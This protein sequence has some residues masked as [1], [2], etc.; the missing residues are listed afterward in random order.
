MRECKRSYFPSERMSISS[1]CHISIIEAIFFS[2]LFTFDTI[3]S[4]NVSLSLVSDLITRKERE[5]ERERFEQ[6]LSAFGD[7]SILFE[8]S[9]KTDEDD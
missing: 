2:F 7:L 9:I 5:R 6:I 3:F 1:T 8:Q 4:V